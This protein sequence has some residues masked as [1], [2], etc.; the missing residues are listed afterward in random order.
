MAT[1]L[2]CLGLFE[3]RRAKKRES[4]WD[5]FEAPAKQKMESKWDVFDNNIFSEI[6][7]SCT[8]DINTEMENTIKGRKKSVSYSTTTQMPT[9]MKT[10]CEAEGHQ[11]ENII[12]EMMSLIDHRNTGMVEFPEFIETITLKVW[13]D[14]ITVGYRGKNKVYL[15]YMT[16]YFS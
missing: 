16:T 9:Q 1:V 15:H 10:K 2:Q 4:R 11:R 3:T 13:Q 6:C 7:P 12:G 8:H 5:V 14:A